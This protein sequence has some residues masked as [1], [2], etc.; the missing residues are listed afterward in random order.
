MSIK[1]AALLFA[2]GW[3]IAGPVAAQQPR[4]TGPVPSVV[5]SERTQ[6]AYTNL[7]IPNLAS[8]RPTHWKRGAL[9][10]G[11]IASAAW[12]VASIATTRSCSLSSC[13]AVTI[14]VTPVAFL[15]GALPGSLIGA[16]FPKDTISP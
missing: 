16:Q 6:V 10:G 1:R 5:I 11:G 13:T 9:I 12:V 14:L 8:P 2:N 7:E 3:V 4:I 15:L